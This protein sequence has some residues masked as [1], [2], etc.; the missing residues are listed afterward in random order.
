MTSLFI[1]LAQDDRRRR[2]GFRLIQIPMKINIDEVVS[3]NRGL[4]V[5]VV[6]PGTFDLLESKFHKETWPVNF[7]PYLSI[8]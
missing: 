1:G 5:S 4:C 6:Y 3:D 7:S 8:I 2:I